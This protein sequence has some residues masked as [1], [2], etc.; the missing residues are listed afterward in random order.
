M[1]NLLLAIV[2]FLVPLGVFADSYTAMW[3]KVEEAQKKD[4][5]KTEIS[6][7]RQIA[8]KAAKEKQYGHLLKS[9]LMAA[10]LET[11]ISPDSVSK[12]IASIEKSYE[13]ANDP[14]LKAVYASVLGRLYKGRAESGD[15][16]S[17]AK[18]R[19]WY[20]LSMGNP[21]MLAAHKSVDYE[22]ALEKGIDSGIFYG[23]LL[24][25]I[26]I[27]AD[28]YKTLHDY[29]AK[30][31]NRTAACICALKSLQESR[32][33]NMG[34]KQRA[35]YLHRLD[36][37]LK[38]YGDLREAGE[39]AVE[40]YNVSASDE[41]ADPQKLVSYINYA[42]S[43]WGTWPRMSVLR[44]RL[45]ELQQPSFTINV[46][47]CMMLPNMPRKLA[48]NS[49]R[50][51]QE[52]NINVYKVNTTGDTH[53]DP[54]DSKDY[55]KLKSL[56]SASPTF[57]V[58]RR[59]IGQ[60][61]WK[62][63]S[64]TVSI[65]G[66][67]IGVYL[68]EATTSNSSIKPQREL[69]RVS[70]LFLMKESL[71]DKNIRYAVVNA[72]SGKPVSGANIRLTTYN[73][74]AK[75]VQTLTTD[76]NGEATCKYEKSAPRL[77]WAYTT[78][79]KACG[80]F[81]V[82]TYYTFW[83]SETRLAKRAEV[84]TDRSIYRPGQTV[85][86]A[87][88]L[89]TANKDSL[90]SKATVSMPVTF[91]LRD[92]NGKTV[93]EK[94]S[95]TD[96]YGTASADFVL[97]TSGLTGN[98]V[99]YANASDHI[100][101][102]SFRV[103]QYK[104]P[105]FQVTF[106]KYKDAY[107]AGDTI[108]IRG[109]ATTY[110]GMPVQDAKVEYTVVRRKGL[111]WFRIGN[112]TEMMTDSVTTA[113]DGSF[114]VRVP[115][116]FPDDANLS[117]A[118]YFNIDITAKV[119]D[120]AG[121]TH[122]GTTTLPL[123]NR[124][125]TLAADLPEKALKDSLRAITFSYKNLSGEEIP[126]KISFRFDGGAWQTADSQKPAPVALKSGK[127]SLEAV[128]GND[129]LKKEV[130]VFSYS[131][132]RPAAETNDWF[133][134]SD[135]QFPAD[136]SP[137]YLQVGSSAEATQVYWTVCS[138]KKVIA[139]GTRP[140]GNTVLTRKIQYRKEYGD[141]I[142]ISQAW[143]VGGKLYQHE[144]SISRPQPD[145]KLRLTWKTFRDKLTPG[146]KETWTLHVSSPDGK[147]AK[148][149]LLSAMYDK[150]LDAI[151]AHRWNF[152][153]S[154]YFNLPSCRWRGGSDGTTIGLY[155]FQNINYYKE[156]DLSFTHFSDDMF[157][158]WLLPI[159]IGSVPGV[160]GLGGSRMY[161]TRAMAKPM[162]M[163]MAL[164]E[165]AVTN[166]VAIDAE[167]SMAN[168]EVANDEYG[169][170]ET[171]NIHGENAQVRENLNE[172]AFFYPNLLTDAQ[173]NVDITFTLPE[174]VTTWRFMGIA[175]DSLMNNGMI[176]AEAVA[177]KSVMVQPNMPRFLRE[178]DKATITTS[179][180]NTTDQ[181]QIGTARLEI[182][183][184]ETGHVLT[185]ARQSFTLLPNGSQTATFDVDAAELAS[186]AGS[187]TL[188][189]ARVYAEGRGFS[190]GEQ[191]YLPLLPDKE[192][193]LNTIPFYQN[194][195]GEKTLDLANLFPADSKDRKLT[196]EYVNNPAWLVVQALPTVANPSEKNAVS[197]VTGIYANA[198]GRTIVA[199]SPKIASTIK[200]WQQETGSATSLTSNLEKDEDLKSL[201][202]DETPWVTD[203]NSETDQ[204]KQLA[205]FLDE[206]TIDYRINDFTS[207][208]A[209]L[210]NSDG[211][212]S[213]WPGMRG[214][215]YITTYVV[216]TLTRL[217]SML[218]KQDFTATMLSKAF[219]FLDAE[220]AKEVAELRKAE[221]KGVKNL[222]PSVT[223]CHYLYASALAG[224][225]QTAD[226]T[227]LV[228]LLDKAPAQLTIYGKAGTAVV[229]AQYGRLKH[230]KEYLQSI[231]EY[232]VFTDEAGRYFDTP[233][234]QYSWFDY[235]I[236]TQT[237]AIEALKRL[238]PTDTVTI[239]DMQRWLLH[240]KRTT[241]W[242]TPVNSVNA[243]YAFLFDAKGKLES[244]K[245]DTGANAVMRLDGQTL[246]LPKATAGIGFVKVSPDDT[247]PKSLTV[248][249]TSKGTSWGAVYGQFLQKASN[250]SN[251]AS[252]LKVKREIMAADGKAVASGM[253][254]GDKVKVRITVVADRDYD[255][256]QLQDKRAACLEPVGQLSGYHWSNGGG[257]YCAPQD[258]VTNY[259]FDR[260]SKGT[261][262]V[263]TAYYVD[264]QG[265]YSTG[266]CTVQCAYAPEFS[267]REAAKNI[268]I[269]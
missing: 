257:Y 150:S 114:K 61:A 129:T 60:P 36:S 178:G 233:K 94:H 223:A 1:K 182:A 51:I 159:G 102:T 78:D 20:K 170:A 191:H 218:G 13:Q 71:P 184:P 267:G 253:K 193:V 100:S 41:N 26:G 57:T 124:T 269:K 37:L 115:M 160:R 238:A 243:V 68:L 229:L 91:T 220:I 141:G 228:N 140:L 84:Y 212:F 167:S 262:V 35:Y 16:P 249:K 86:A 190:D 210:Q 82:S 6:V 172:T 260:L 118:L 187:Q 85:H 32:S 145:T 173:G 49:I 89:W 64:D 161:K 70:D 133:Y 204:K 181:R 156:R 77:S 44:N 101:T 7:L 165:S 217:N 221:K 214:S 136:G 122:E 179:I 10:G 211:S 50:N 125:A 208:L 152:D 25:V 149:Q 199:S 247:D 244:D 74:N 69:L 138:G 265:D 130:V 148:T 45:F 163:S 52:L 248:D 87:A 95:T 232:T 15:D 131:D 258:N 157:E 189:V 176:D 147:P 209:A 252:G 139:S 227:Y 59:Y 126:G 106:D 110:S 200:L 134:V 48:V 236:P 143:V 17:T 111:P 113:D 263:E 56:M 76:H 264:R 55:V 245:L 33:G 234:A 219:G 213:W 197:L 225:P 205:S 153:N 268:S 88:I 146:Q 29:Y 121:E 207:K 242:S 103:E 166:N 185:E 251:A 255:F 109:V 28:D 75:S 254:V 120:N 53:L 39:I 142:T 237:F 99:I 137:V 216:E 206:S 222:Q 97:P 117:R 31:G 79:D 93:S 259:Y 23:D 235:R 47:D 58:T 21:S 90:T 224:R 8:S 67:P 62:E 105:T 92:A 116:L 66:L 83:D 108:V 73:G 164:Q 96:S 246:D 65:D 40:Y 266:I 43:K 63:N 168:R 231:R 241:G 14:A 3:K 12:N 42:L 186:K 127:H 34:K 195:A 81:G 4:L 169:E 104:R 22:P 194:G 240:E 19:E 155:G 132:K 80:E 188:L 177:S 256:V 38:V 158:P 2:G 175:H 154:F 196:I 226:K 183:D 162:A 11:S 215:S 72:T 202:L 30:D 151:Y 198:I 9:Q 174:S 201:V 250:V 27:E 5:P 119:T 230:A 128:C 203:A 192:Q 46:G 54:S 135:A 123:S 180:F 112:S 24:H 18:S 98:F 171:G 107:N 144:A 261:H 239:A